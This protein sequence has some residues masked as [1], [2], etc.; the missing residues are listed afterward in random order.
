MSGALKEV[1][2]RIT[3]VKKTQQIT[4]AMKMVAA[5]KLRRAQQAI[6]Q[7]RPYADKQQQILINLLSN[8]DG[9]VSSSYGVEREVN[10]VCMVVVTSNRGLAGAF[11]TNII[12]AAVYTLENEF[13]EQLAVGNVSVLTIG[14]KAADFFKRNYSDKATII[15]DYTSLF[16]DLSFDNVSRVSSELMRAFENGTYDAVRVAYSHFRN[17]VI[18]EAQVEV[19]LPVPK[20]EAEEGEA[21]TRAN[22]IFEPDKEQL[23]NYLIP[24]ILQTQFHKY[25]LDTHASEHGARMTAM[26]NA[27]ENAEELQ[28][29][30]K[31]AYNKARQEAITK[32]ISEIVGGAAALEG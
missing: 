11:N 12:K 16:E 3:S 4:K 27:T 18:Q 17:V 24:S 23:L 14:K 20:I 28:K 5:A 6:S 10:K 21:Q 19:Y 9:D 7:M 8:L 2:E 26:D 22:Y 15:T 32:E 30:L 29:E 1:R 13:S 25:L 31:I